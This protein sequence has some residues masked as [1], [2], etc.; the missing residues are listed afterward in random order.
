MIQFDPRRTLVQPEKHAGSNRNF[1]KTARIRVADM[2]DGSRGVGIISSPLVIC[3][4][5]KVA[6]AWADALHD[7]ADA[8]EQE[9]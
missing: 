6:R 4:S 7:A 3:V 2:A 8:A 1:A 9:D 5:P